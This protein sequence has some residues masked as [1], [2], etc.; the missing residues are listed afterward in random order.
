MD[1]VFKNKINFINTIYNLIF[2]FTLTKIFFLYFYADIT[3]KNFIYLILIFI[4]FINSWMI[5][6]IHLNRYGKN[7]FLNLVFMLAQGITLLFLIIK[8]NFDIKYLLACLVIFSAILSI[9]HIL[10]YIFTEK[11]NLIIKKLTEPFCYILTCRTFSLLLGLWFTDYS[12][13]FIFISFLISQLLPSFISRTLHVKTINFPNL[14][15]QLWKLIITLIITLIIFNYFK[16]GFGKNLLVTCFSLL[17]L[18]TIYQYNF[19]NI[20]K[21][22]D[23]ESGNSFIFASYL[24]ILSIYIINFSFI[25]IDNFWLIMNLFFG[26]VLFFSGMKIYKQYRK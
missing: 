22:L 17:I 4:I 19:H 11:E 2:I 26:G 13:F 25:K 23:K 5:E 15:F 16:L 7:S 8:N 20:N 21:M 10:E 18:L 9:Q 1:L 3:I 6:I 12:Y 14:T 24:I